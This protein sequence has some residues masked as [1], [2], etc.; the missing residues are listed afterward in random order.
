MQ[1]TNDNLS[2]S[3]GAYDDRGLYDNGDG[4]YGGARYEDGRYDQQV[5][6]DEDGAREEEGQYAWADSDGAQQ[7]LS[8]DL[9]DMMGAD[10]FD[11]LVRSLL[12]QG[13]PA[14]AAALC[15][16]S[17]RARALCQASRAN[18]ARDFPDLES[19]YGVSAAV[20][21]SRPL[22][23]PSVGP[24]PVSSDD[25]DD[26]DDDND[27]GTVEYNLLQTALAR[28][29]AEVA[30]RFCAMYALYVRD[31]IVRVALERQRAH[32]RDV[33]SG[34]ASQTRHVALL[35]EEQ[36]PLEDRGVRA[37]GRGIA[38]A[39]RRVV[40]RSLRGS[41]SF[42]K[43]LQSEVAPHRDVVDVLRSPDVVSL[44]D[45]EDWA[46]GL[47]GISGY[48]LRVPFSGAEPWAVVQL[49]DE[50]QVPFDDPDAGPLFFVINVSPPSGAVANLQDRRLHINRR[51]GIR[52]SES[53]IIGADLDAIA[54]S[55]AQAAREFRDLVRYRVNR[56]LDEALGKAV[57]LRTGPGQGR[58]RRGVQ[59]PSRPAG[60]VDPSE[61][62]LDAL[63]RLRDRCQH[64]DLYRA[65]AP[66]STYIAALL[67]PGTDIVT[68]DVVVR[69]P[70]GQSSASRI[71]DDF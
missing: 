5:Q 35:G 13:R 18:W 61:T 54:R 39:L 17:R 45:L 9:I 55:D 47:S 52:P 37:R 29:R 66:V 8:G 50:P 43:S 16:S 53:E 58:Q 56:A 67:F 27:H 51:T 1:F 69:L 10:V 2:D 60:E 4:L 3:D 30:E 24:P 68:Y 48:P 71:A 26:D 36:S 40:P 11:A 25:D 41:S 22:W 65:Y 6:Y 19:A 70:L 49:G 15:S 46:R 32:A 14:D 12:A 28:R 44:A 7:G 31:H 21:G 62:T 42:R 38:Q 33:E 20:V 57:R 64:I 63:T 34:A 59:R 23:P